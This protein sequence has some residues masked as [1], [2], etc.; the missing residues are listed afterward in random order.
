MFG[1]HSHPKLHHTFLYI[2]SNF[3]FFFL[4]FSDKEEDKIETGRNNTE[5]FVPLHPSGMQFAILWGKKQILIV[6]NT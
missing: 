3:F 5:F 6:A 1:R 2:F 4:N